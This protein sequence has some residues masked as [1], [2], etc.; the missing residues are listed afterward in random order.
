MVD[1]SL[2]QDFAHKFLR[3]LWARDDFLYP[4]T[5]EFRTF[6]PSDVVIVVAA[7]IKGAPVNHELVEFFINLE[8]SHCSWVHKFL[9]TKFTLELIVTGMLPSC[10]TFGGSNEVDLA[11]RVVGDW[12]GIKVDCRW[13]TTSINSIT[14]LLVNIVVIRVCRCASW[15]K[16]SPTPCA[17][18]LSLR[19]GE[20]PKCTC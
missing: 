2:I 20:V 3:Q 6:T 11:I 19:L 18:I 4:G 12:E 9:S 14:S 7:I 8:T 15:S 13:S 10:I 1:F 16:L 5:K 17:K